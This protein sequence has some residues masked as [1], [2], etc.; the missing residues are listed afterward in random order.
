MVPDEHGDG[1]PPTAE[2][3]RE[4]L[5]E[6]ARL[7][8]MLSPGQVPA[9]IPVLMETVAPAPSGPATGVT[10]ARRPRPAADER[11]QSLFEAPPDEADRLARIQAEATRQLEKLAPRAARAPA[12]AKNPASP[13]PGAP[14]PPPAGTASAHEA[15]RDLLPDIVAEV[16]GQFMPRIRK[17]I[18]ARLLE[19]LQRRRQEQDTP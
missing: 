13:A 15:A 11:Q 9:A 16:V 2:E 17:A 12:R 14:T 1:T 8:E 18:E 5:A 3:R 7:Q 6:L 10:G 4:M 19:E